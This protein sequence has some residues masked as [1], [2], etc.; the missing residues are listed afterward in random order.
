LSPV[1]KVVDLWF[2]GIEGLDWHLTRSDSGH[3]RRP[4]RTVYGFDRHRMGGPD[5]HVV[6]VGPM[7][8]VDPMVRLDKG[9]LRLKNH[10]QMKWLNHVALLRIAY[11]PKEELVL[12]L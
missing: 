7:L 8:R 12:L 2:I 3:S 10:L 11:V 9:P 4:C 5:R 6:G 1:R